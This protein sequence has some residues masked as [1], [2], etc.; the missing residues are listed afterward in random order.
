MTDAT[1]SDAGRATLQEQ[2]S[3]HE[4]AYKRIEARIQAV[5]AAYEAADEETR[6]TALKRAYAYAVLTANSPLEA[7][8]RSYARWLQGDSPRAVCVEERHTNRKGD[9]FASGLENF[10]E[11]ARPVDRKILAGEYG[12]AAEIAAENL[13]G[14]SRVKARFMVGLL[15]GETACI[16]T[17][18]ERFVRTHVTDGDDLADAKNNSSPEK[19]ETATKALQT[20]A[21]GVSRF[22]AQWISFDAARGTFTPHDNF[23]TSLP[24]AVA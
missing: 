19:Y 9:W 13:T 16:D 21:P 5:K 7:A 12:E 14:I 4:A 6:L 11:K 1:L 2:Y 10:A 23:Y 18:A 24:F 17:H 3:A 15:T 8:D 22:I 20:G